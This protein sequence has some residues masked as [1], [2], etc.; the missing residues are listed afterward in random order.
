VVECDVCIVGAGA[1]GIT[2]ARDLLGAR[3]RVCLLESGDFELDPATQDLYRGTNGGRPYATLESTRLRYF[4]GTTNHW[5]GWCA[6]LVACD[7]EPRSWVPHSGWPLTLAELEPFY[8]RA[9]RINQLGPFDYRP[10]TWATSS[11]PTLDA[12]ED[13]ETVMWQFSPPTKYGV[14]YREELRQAQD[15][16]VF[17]N[18]NL[19]GFITQSPQRVEA[20]T[21]KTLAGTSFTVEARFVVLAC[22]GI[23]NA[24]ILLLA[25]DDDAQPL[26]ASRDLI[27][28]FFMEHLHLE[29]G[30]CVFTD[31]AAN[32]DLYVRKRL[33]SLSTG[34]KRVDTVLV[35]ILRDLDMFGDP[36]RTQAGLRISD[37][38]QRR[39]RILNAVSILYPTRQLGTLGRDVQRTVSI[40]AFPESHDVAGC[41][42]RMLLEQAPNPASRV[43]LSDERDSLGQ[44]RPRLEW[45]LSPLDVH[46]LSAATR[47]FALAFGQAD[48]G[49]VQLEK[50][51]LEEPE[52]WQ[53]VYW[54]CHHMGT[55]RMS[56]D[57]KLG[58]VDRDCRVHG[59]DNLFV[60]G[61]SVFPT[62]GCVNPTLTITA[63]AHRLADRLESLL[64]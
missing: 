4:G 34:V 20:L 61:S 55:T 53:E 39:E 64:S 26:A 19:T 10:E 42:V 11:R 17:L 21:V 59:V 52:T 9:Q 51:V 57:P 45:R 22:G 16:D 44:R 12:G 35:R 28:R 1:A 50:W 2:V 63:L 47:R 8:R 29:T 48:L 23:E 56:D 54:G 36:V 60:A 46:T 40:A 38:A 33:R 58:V 31:P 24:R 6:P 5:E 27:G 3:A 15:L 30:L 14:A 18:A 13:L 49:R 37:D 43:V 25:M 32:P 41:R 7:F 62:V